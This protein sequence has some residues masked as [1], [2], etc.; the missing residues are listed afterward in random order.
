MYAGTRG[1]EVSAPAYPTL[2]EEPI[3]EAVLVAGYATPPNTAS[4]PVL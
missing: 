4:E 3:A 1:Y 2:N